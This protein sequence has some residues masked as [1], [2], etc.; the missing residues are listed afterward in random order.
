MVVVMSRIEYIWRASCQVALNELDDEGPLEPLWWGSGFFL[1]HK[2][3]LYFV[4]ADHCIHPDDYA[5]IGDRRNGK[6]YNRHIL[7]NRNVDGEL[8]SHIQPL[9]DFYYFDKKDED[10]P[11]IIDKLDV[12]ITKVMP[13][14]LDKLLTTNWIDPKNGNDLVPAGLTRV[15]INSDTA[16]KPNSE[17]RY[18]VVGCIHNKS[19]GVKAHRESIGY[20]DL[21]Y[22]EMSDKEIVLSTPILGST[23]NDWESLS[24]SPVFN[25]KGEIL[26]MLTREVS[27]DQRLRVIPIERIL[28]C[29][30][31]VE[32]EFAKE[33]YEIRN[34]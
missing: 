15:P 25:Y 27:E 23:H 30:E 7:T 4:T 12:A 18:I 21:T 20:C 9:Y 2:G 28:K 3:N 13:S 10:F 16:T 26:G 24:G 34:L 17:D 1:T 14:M 32:K 8:A 19:N 6:E 11:E 33:R 31:V 5:P 22:V 29:V